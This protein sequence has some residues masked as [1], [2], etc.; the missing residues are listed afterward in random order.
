M[1]VE[2]VMKR[3]ARELEERSARAAA[4]SEGDPSYWGALDAV[5]AAIIRALAE[6]TEEEAE[7]L[8]D[9]P[10]HPAVIVNEALKRVE[11]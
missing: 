8:L 11:R 1:D 9:D 3:V 7:R 10:D 2:S 5:A 4:S 6:A